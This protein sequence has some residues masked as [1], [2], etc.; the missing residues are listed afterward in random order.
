MVATVTIAEFNTGDETETTAITNT[1][2]GST[3]APNLVATTYPITAGT[4]SYEKW[5]KFRVSDAGGSSSIQNLK[6]WIS[7]ALGS[8]ATLYTNANETTW[9]AETF[10]TPVNSTSS[11]A[12]TPMP[13]STPASANVGI[14]G[15]LGGVLDI[16]SGLPKYSDYLVMQ[17]ALTAGAATGTVVTMNYQYDE[18]A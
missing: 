2:M 11:V 12:A 3:D 16:T 17:I 8:G 5:Q 4:R 13:T 6:V 18:V 9:T 1:N 10:A 14:G 15:N 7:A